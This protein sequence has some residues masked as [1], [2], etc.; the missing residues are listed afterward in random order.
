MKKFCGIQKRLYFCTQ[1]ASPASRKNSALRGGFLFFILFTMMKNIY[2]KPFLTCDAQ[3][4]L[5]KSRGMLFYDEIKASHLLKYISYYRFSGYWYPLLD[6]KQLH[7]FKPNSYF[8]TAL[9]LYK[10]DSE[11][12]KL[13]TSEFRHHLSHWKSLLLVLFHV[14][15]KI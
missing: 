6:N 4:A 12:R 1:R 13:I 7:I 2:L 15:T 10:F 5:L 9:C 3:I 8:E 14:C 11:L